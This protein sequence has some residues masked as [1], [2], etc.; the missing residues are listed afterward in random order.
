MK[1]VGYE[2]ILIIGVLI[3][4]GFSF[5]Q[6]RGIFYGQQL[7]GKEEVIN[8]FAKDLEEIVDK[9]MATTGDAAFIYHPAIKQYSVL[10]KNSTVIV[11]DKISKHFLF[12]LKIFCDY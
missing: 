11:T 9:A 8:A 7:M 10:V 12:F 2:S 1:S 4:I 6:L 5:F 3:A